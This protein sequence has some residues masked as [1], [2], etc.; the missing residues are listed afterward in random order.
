MLK[1]GEAAWF[2]AH[3]TMPKLRKGS[4][5]DDL[6]DDGGPLAGLRELVL[7]RY[8][9]GKAPK[10]APVADEH[11]GLRDGFEPPEELVARAGLKEAYSF[12]SKVVGSIPG[13]GQEV[14]PG[15]FVVVTVEREKQQDPPTGSDGG[16]VPIPPLPDDDDDDVNTP[17]WLC[18]T[19]FC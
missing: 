11:P 6:T 8:A 5:A 1:N 14:R 16:S 17:G 3:P 15:R 19:R 4:P 2:A 10:D 12:D 13:A 9:K 18:P 7:L